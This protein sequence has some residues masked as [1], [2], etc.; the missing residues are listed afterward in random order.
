MRYAVR[1][2][3]YKKV[4]I[5]TNPYEGLKRRFKPFKTESDKVS[6]TTNPYE[7]LKLD[8]C[9]RQTVFLVSITTNPYEGLKLRD[10]L[11]ALN[12]YRFQ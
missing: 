7:G 5:T 4:S 1:G 12:Y 6:I 11:L 2:R 8:K 10:N 3:K 9:N